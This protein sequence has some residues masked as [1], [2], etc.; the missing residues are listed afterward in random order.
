MRKSCWR[1][2]PATLRIQLSLICS[3]KQ[4][5][6]RTS[7][8]FLPHAAVG[9]PTNPKSGRHILASSKGTP[10]A[11]CS[12]KPIARVFSVEAVLFAHRSPSSMV[13]LF[14]TPQVQYLIRSLAFG[15][16]C[17]SEERR[18]GKECRSWGVRDG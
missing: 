2:R 10:L 5:L 14:P 15:V 7:A 16:A 1:H 3:Y 18:V 13:S 11:A 17:R 8:L 4:S 6:R 9:R 12:S